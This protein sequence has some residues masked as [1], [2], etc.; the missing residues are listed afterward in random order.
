LI[1]PFWDDLDPRPAPTGTGDIYYAHDAANHRWIVEFR[2][3]GHIGDTSHRET[4]QMQLRDPQYYTTPTGDGEILF[5][6]DTISIADSNTVGIEDHT[7]TR[8]IQY[9]YNGNY[10]QNA[11]P[12]VN[13][14][15]ILITTKAPAGIWL[16]TIYYTFDDSTGGNNNGIIEPGEAIDIYV[17]IQNSGNTTANDVTA[18]L[19]TNDPDA[20]IIDSTA[21]FGTITAG[22]TASNYGSPYVA[23]ISATPSDTTIGFALYISCNNGSYQKSDYFTFYIYGPPGVEEQKIAAL[24]SV[25]L[26]VYPN[27]FKHQLA[28]R[29]AGLN[30]ILGFLSPGEVQLNIYDVC[31]RVVKSF[32]E[33]TSEQVTWDGTDE[34]GRHVAS[35]VYFVD[36]NIKG[37]QQGTKVILLK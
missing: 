10:H 11:A 26:N 23:Q 29:A 28:I 20:T 34:N 36:L 37:N 33:L 9:V 32:N 16:H 19:Q 31:G 4:F 35:G 15:A 17:H 22:Q 3:V 6:Y 5:L 30:R 24:S 27:P 21:S 12:L 2:S 14:R 7:Q 8:G 13:D 25:G 1:A 18:T